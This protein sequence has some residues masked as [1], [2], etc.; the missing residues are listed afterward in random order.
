MKNVINFLLILI[1]FNSCLETL[2]SNK[3]VGLIV[4][5]GI[6]SIPAD[7]KSTVTLVSYI[8][9]DSDEDKR[10]IEFHTSGGVFTKN[11]EN[12]LSVIARD[13]VEI[14]N[15]KYLS[16]E[17]ILRSSNTIAPE[18]I[19]TTRVKSFSAKTY[20]AFTESVPNKV[21]LS[22]N[23]FGI[24]NSYDSEVILTALVES[25]SGFPSNG[26]T[27]EFLVYDAENGSKFSN[28]LFRERKLSVNSEGKASVIFSS[29]NLMKGDTSF[30]G[31]LL[32]KVNILNVPTLED[33]I[34]LNV[35][36]KTD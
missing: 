31:D 28:P 8:S 11:N 12:T 4:K 30:L 32:I 1:L 15:Q 29:G 16:A 36:K 17:A 3:V 26:Y 2:D 5:N 25:F 24:V 7:N 19:V 23:K 34:I 13:T 22:S 18:I 6:T 27:V 20:L 33:S 10:S 21:L 14:E 9:I 35:S